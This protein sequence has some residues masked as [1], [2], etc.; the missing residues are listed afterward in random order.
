MAEHQ[1]PMMKVDESGN[2][3]LN[4]GEYG[5]EVE[6]ACFSKD[7]SRLLTVEKVGVAKVFDTETSELVGEIRPVSDLAGSDKSPTTKAFEVYI[8][9]V[10]LDS[11]GQLAL[12][13]LNDGTAGVF[14]VSTGKRLSTLLQNETPPEHWELI[15]AVNF[16]NDG[17]LALVGFYNRTVGVWNTTGEQLIAKLRP[18]S[19]D[20]FFSKELWGRDSLV[21]SVAASADNRYIF[22]GCSDY[23]CIIW[24]L[25]EQ[26]PV[27]TA[28]EYREETICICGI[29]DAV[30]WA[31]AGGAVWRAVN[32]SMPEKLYSSE[33]NWVEA[34]IA[35]SG[36]LLLAITMAGEI[37]KI[38]LQDK[39]IDVLAN[40]D[41]KE[42]FK[43]RTAIGFL[44]GDNYFY[45]PSHDSIKLAD[46]T[47][48]VIEEEE[49][50]EEERHDTIKSVRP[51]PDNSILAIE[52][53]WK[54]RS[55]WDRASGQFIRKLPSSIHHWAFSSDGSKIAF[56]TKD[57][58]R[59]YIQ[60]EEV[61]T[62]QLVQKFIV[63]GSNDVFFAFDQTDDRLITGSAKDHTMRLWKRINSAD[64]P[65]GKYTEV[66]KQTYPFNQQFI[67]AFLPEGNIVVGRRGSD[68]E[69]WSPELTTKICCD[70]KLDYDPLCCINENRREFILAESEQTFYKVDLTTGTARG[71]KPQLDRPE[72]VPNSQLSKEFNYRCGAALWR[73]FGGPYVHITDGPRGWTTPI[74]IS[75]DQKFVVLPGQ[76][77]IAVISIADEQSIRARLPF[78]GRLR[79]AYVDHE[80]VMAVDSKGKLI[81]KNYGEE[82]RS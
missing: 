21:S 2:L 52:T 81:A 65:H 10:A 47:F 42:L 55:L 69:V 13:G 14:E 50:E 9:A 56:S 43:K 53:D 63:H 49:E 48:Q 3:W 25:E 58:E 31:T 39:K 22:V 57:S 82:S 5:Q 75:L 34:K 35:P 32:N 70:I 76:G 8:E 66:K 6:L 28:T 33:Q 80:K 41:P 16:S 78:E 61:R 7:G 38:S 20:L 17:S 44:D 23:T 24:D 59:G 29:A 40:I 72:Y 51:S 64:S 15:R 37:Q 26:K 12:L 71:F 36:S 45:T 74:H 73:G 19:A 4:F 62:G 54:G 18:N 1:H 11:K 77:E 27:Y 67:F 30:Y 60:I 79:A 68:L 46:I